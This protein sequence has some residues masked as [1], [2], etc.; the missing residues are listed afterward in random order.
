MV[1]FNDE[2]QLKKF[3]KVSEIINTFCR[4]RLN[5][6]GKRK[7]YMLKAMDRELRIYENKVRFIGAV[8]SKTIDIMNNEDDVVINQLE[9]E[10]FDKENDSYDYLLKLQIRSFTGNKI[11]ELTNQI[12]ILLEKITFVVFICSDLGI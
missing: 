11:R 12:N 8:I 1:L 7:Q 3:N 5:F 10:N 4:V 2:Q 6:Y 9:S